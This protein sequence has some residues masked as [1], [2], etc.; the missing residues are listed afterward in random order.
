MLELLG[1]SRHELPRVVAHLEAVVNGMWARA[2]VGA[3][4]RGPSS[5]KMFLQTLLAE[6]AAQ[7][8]LRH[9]LQGATN[10][11]GRRFRP[12]LEDIIE[13]LI[14]REARQG[15][16]WRKV[17]TGSAR[18]SFGLAIRPYPEVAMAQLRKD[19]VLPT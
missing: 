5:D 14:V 9:H 6:G 13:F 18:S 10:R 16:T 12:T 7:D 11:G 1:T 19:E 15:A 4:H 17:G 2:E 3:V 8:A